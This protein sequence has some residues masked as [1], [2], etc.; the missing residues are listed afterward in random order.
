MFKLMNTLFHFI[1][2]KLAIPVGTGISLW[3]YSNWQNFMDKTSP[4]IV[5]IGIV[6]GALLGLSGFVLNIKKIKSNNDKN[7]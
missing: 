2:E 4:T 7:K 1:T 3:S 6:A 5:Y